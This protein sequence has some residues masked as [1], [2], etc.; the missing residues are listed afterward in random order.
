VKR[1]FTH[2]QWGVYFA[3]VLAGAAAAMSSK[4]A[5]RSGGV[6]VIGFVVGA[7]MWL[8]GTHIQ[9]RFLLALVPAGAGVMGAGCGCG[10]WRRAA[11][12]AL[13]CVGAA[14]GAFMV[15]T[16][17]GEGAASA[18]LTVMPVDVMRAAGGRYQTPEMAMNAIWEREPGAKVALIGSATPLYYRKPVEYA[19]AWDAGAFDAG[20]LRSRGVRYA[21]IDF[22]E[23]VRLRASGY[24]HPGV[25]PEAVGAWA[26]REA[27]VVGEWPGR[28]QVLVEV[29]R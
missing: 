25:D 27:R 19:T 10:R 22:V 2:G 24:L 14:Q 21:V 26:R 13:V 28:G 8:L 7:G 16:L 5:R 23:L 29:A 15:W 18:M 11:V 6:L 4:P 9:S 17:R 3:A 1:G 12:V 20:A